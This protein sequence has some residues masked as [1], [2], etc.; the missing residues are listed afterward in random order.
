MDSTALT[1]TIAGTLFLAVLV[2]WCLRWMFSRLNRA[3]RGDPSA[4]G[5]M[6]ARLL[7]AEEAQ[8]M[9]E[10]KLV[11]VEVDLHKKLSQTEAELAATFETLGS[12]RRELEAANHAL[13]AR[14][15]N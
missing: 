6:A 14:E 2:G 4:Q 3:N 1:Y 9:A 8:K 12:V 10:A 5:D 15:G 11:S 7:A 13:A